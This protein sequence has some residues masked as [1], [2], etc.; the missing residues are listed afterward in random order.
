[1]AFPFV[2]GPL[3]ESL[4]H[5]F[6]SDLQASLAD[7]NG[8]IRELPENP[9]AHALS[10]AVRFYHHVSNRI[11]ER[12]NLSIVGVLLGSG[13]A[14]PPAMQKEIGGLLRRAQN[15]AVAPLQRNP[16]DVAATFALCVV[17]SVNRDGLSLVSKRWSASLAHAERA[18]ALARRLLE[19]DP[20]AHDAYFVFGFTEFLLSRIPAA[21]RGF[22]RIPGAT[23]D[24]KKALRYCQ[25]AAESGWYFREFARRTLVDLYLE[26]G[27]PLEGLKLLNELVSEFPGNPLLR[28]DCERL[29]SAPSTRGSV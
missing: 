22:A 16:H 24:R 19:D 28:A 23:G 12:N 7:L 5:L 8:Y 3:R 29:R 27:R 13:I 9:L 25:I 11:P 15:L 18:H 6:N 20:S 10:A 26:D 1:M 2:E 21:V 17:E 14:M 4:R